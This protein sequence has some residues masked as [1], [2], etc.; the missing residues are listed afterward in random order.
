MSGFYEELAEILEVEPDQVTADLRL[1]STSWDS[2]A[3][4][5]TIA[6]IDEQYDK[7]VNA[8]ALAA[9]ET[10]GDIERL[11]AARSTESEA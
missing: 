5:S 1:E 9:C 7:A 2:L 8:T 4:V 3:V 11:I 10:V 6:L